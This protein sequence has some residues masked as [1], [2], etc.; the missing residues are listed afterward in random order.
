MPKGGYRK[1]AGRKPSAK[2]VAKDP[3]VTLHIPADWHSAIP[4]VKARYVREA[5]RMRMES[6]RLL[7]EHKDEPVMVCIFGGEE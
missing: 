6:E 1:G 7:G 2:P 4:G 5:L 3:V